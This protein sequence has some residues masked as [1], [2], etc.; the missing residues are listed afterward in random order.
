MCSNRKCVV[1]EVAADEVPYFWRKEL[2]SLGDGEELPLEAKATAPMNSKQW[3]VDDIDDIY[4]PEENYIFVRLPDNRESF[5]AFQGA[6]VWTSM[7]EGN[8]MLSESARSKIFGDSSR[9]T[10]S[11]YQFVSGLHASVATHISE[12][13]WDEENQVATTNTTYFLD[14]VG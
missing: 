7:Y 6:K 2:K 13:F 4:A 12:G 5:T 3:C 8:T 1:Y 9:E 11:M 14:H 10:N